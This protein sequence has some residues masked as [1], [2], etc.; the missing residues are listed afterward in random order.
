M[1]SFRPGRWGHEPLGDPP[2]QPISHTRAPSIC[3]HPSFALKLRE[4]QKTCRLRGLDRSSPAQATDAHAQYRLVLLA[5]SAQL[6]PGVVKGRS[7]S[8]M[9]GHLTRGEGAACT[10]ARDA[11]EAGET[12]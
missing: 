12:A 3:G 10:L 9:T 1:T 5:G 7:R 11:I 2:S 4:Q 6:V 8:L